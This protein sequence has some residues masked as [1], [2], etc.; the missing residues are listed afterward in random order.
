MMINV[1]II[2]G[3]VTIINVELGILPKFMLLPQ[4]FSKQG[5]KPKRTHPNKLFILNHWH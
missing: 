2:K 1:V 5:K 3:I 4:M